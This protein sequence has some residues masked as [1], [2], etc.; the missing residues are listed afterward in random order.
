MTTDGTGDILLAVAESI[1]HSLVEARTVQV[2]PGAGG[3]ISGHEV[4]LEAADGTRRSETVYLETD[5]RSTD[6]AGVLHL[7]DDDTGSVVAVWLYPADPE[8]PALPASVFPAAAAALLARL[9]LDATDLTLEVATY[10][11]GKRAVVRMTTASGTFYLKIVRPASAALIADAHAGWASCGLPVPEVLAFSPEGLVAMSPLAGVEAASVVGAIAADD[12]AI[13]TTIDAIHAITTRIGII[14]SDAPARPSLVSRLD[15]YLGRAEWLAG[16]AGIRDLG[17]SIEA[18]YRRGGDPTPNVT[19]HG[20]LHLAQL[21]VDPAQ[22]HR[23]TGV[24]DIDTSGTGDPADDCAALW[25]HCHALAQHRLDQ[26]DARDAGA[27]TRLAARLQARWPGHR[28][29]GLADRATAIAATQL[30]G[31]ALS[32]TIPVARAIALATELVAIR[33]H[34][35]PLTAV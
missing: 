14:P 21:F 10:R 26:G 11:P 18:L 2:E 19:V 15:W 8:L 28:E 34:E 1:G 13:E 4:V 16:S 29:P 20:D 24:L 7:R 5:P 17:A 31:H 27:A 12:A 22:P 33:Q 32:G 6:R 3:I 23:I 25:A 9:S 35:R 30:L